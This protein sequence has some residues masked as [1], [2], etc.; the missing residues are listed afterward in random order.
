MQTAS[1]PFVSRRIV[2]Q[3][4]SGSALAVTGAPLA[5]AADFWNKKPAANWSGDEIEQMKSKS[6]WAKKTRAEMSG[7]GFGGGRGGGGDSMDRSGSNGTFAKKTRAEISGA[8]FSGGRGGGGGRGGEGGGGGA[9]PAGPEVIVRWENAKPMLDAT[10]LALPAE[11][12]SQYAISVT[13]LAPQ[14][15]AGVL[16]GGG[17]GGGRGRGR[18]REGEPTADAAPVPQED[19][20]TRQKAMVDRL[21]HSVSLSAKGQD[22]QNA[23]LIRQTDG[24]MTLIFGFPKDALPLTAADKDVQFTMKLGPLT[25][26][27][28]FEPKDMMYQ[29]EL[30]L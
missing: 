6:P 21:L 20:A 18:G 15:I 30:A 16:S 4:L 14:M 11:L 26:K 28:K 12:A 13:G 7:G 9:V 8:G 19:A 25:V 23:T 27:A 22:P 29:G 17:G 10:K 3:L 1:T 24:N 2:I 5:L